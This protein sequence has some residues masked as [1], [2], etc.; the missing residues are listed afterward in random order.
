MASI[1]KTPDDLRFDRYDSSL[2]G[3]GDLRLSFFDLLINNPLKVEPYCI[4][5]K[6]IYLEKS[7]SL[8]DV[9]MLMS[10]RVDEGVRRGLYFND[11]EAVEKTAEEPDGVLVAMGTL[12][13]QYGKHIPASLR[14]EVRKWSAEA[15][16]ELVKCLALLLGA[17]AQGLT[18]HKMAFQR[19]DRDNL[20]KLA[21]RLHTLPLIEEGDMDWDVYRLI[22]EVDYKFLYAGALDISQAVDR[23]TARLL[24][25]SDELYAPPLRLN[26][27]LGEIQIGTTGDDIFESKRHLFLTIDWGG[28]DTYLN[29]ASSRPPAYPLGITIDL[30]GDDIYTG[31]GSAGT[32][33]QG[34][35]FLT[36]SDGNDR[37][38]AEELGQGCGVFGVGAILDAGGDDIYQSL[39]LA[40]GS[41]QFGLGLL[42]DRRGNDT[43]STYRL[44]QGYG[45]TKGCGL[46]MDCH[47]DD[48]YIANDTDIRFPS[49]QTAEHNG[50]LCQGAGAGLRGDLWHGHSLGGGIGMLIDAQGDDCYQGGIFVQG[51]AYWYAVGMLVDGAGNDLYEGV[52]YTQG[53][54]A[55]F[56]AAALIDESGDD[57]YQASINVAQGGAH[58]FS[59]AMLV[60]RAGNDTY[61]APNLSMGAA[62]AN[63]IGI[64]LDRNGND[65]YETTGSLTL[66]AAQIGVD[67]LSL[68]D[69]MFSFGL[70]M[71]LGGRDSY[72]RAHQGDNRIWNQRQW[73]PR[74]F[75]NNENGIGLDGE[76]AKP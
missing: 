30:K 25:A 46:L 42:I 43:Y 13:M 26:T 29:A 24:S 16:P 56:G 11:L 32:G 19:I 23:A 69:F 1:G 5:S 38:E 52:W 8:H 3:G 70:F 58:D 68:R 72:P 67:Q 45:F 66:G 60:D 37:Y 27:I 12:Y 47:G 62:N 2:F 76:Y 65:R 20:E 71:D 61:Q 59:L 17:S 49:S 51:V 75:F 34:Y 15:H 22:S 40:Q 74:S 63:A 33:I 53:A 14:R 36:D 9:L 39:T 41:G 73:E 57:R 21:D 7:A 54:G 50:N 44:S 6:E 28:N 64:L 48:R 4:R 10:I 31:N 18:W 55:H 35:G